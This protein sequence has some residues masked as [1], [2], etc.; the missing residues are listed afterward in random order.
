[1]EAQHR[2]QVEEEL[3]VLWADVRVLQALGSGKAS[4]VK[5]ETKGKRATRYKDFGKK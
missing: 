1:M 5:S 4:E 2:Q 3:R